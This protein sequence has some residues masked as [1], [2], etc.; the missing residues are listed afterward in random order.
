LPSNL[1]L[2]S[3][4][5]FEGFFMT[6]IFTFREKKMLFLFR[7]RIVIFVQIIFVIIRLE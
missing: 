1:S 7:Q 6:M 5:A 3:A 2:L 4:I